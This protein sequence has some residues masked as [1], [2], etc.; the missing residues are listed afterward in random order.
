MYDYEAVKDLCDPSIGGFQI[1]LTAKYPDNQFEVE[2]GKCRRCAGYLTVKVQ[3]PF[4]DVVIAKCSR[5][6]ANP[7]IEP[8]PR[9]MKRF[10]SRV[11][12][13]HLT[14]WLA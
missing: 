9:W 14:E 4:G 13:L 12:P 5:C 6:K 1:S 11:N 7:G 10:V 3:S 8:L 2:L